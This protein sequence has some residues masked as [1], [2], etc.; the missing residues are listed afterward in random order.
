ME[1][2]LGLSKTKAPI[3]NLVI[4]K[5]NYDFIKK[6]VLNQAIHS[7]KHCD[8]PN[9]IKSIKSLMETFS[10]KEHSELLY[11][12]RPNVDPFNLKSSTLANYRI[13]MAYGYYAYLTHLLDQSRVDWLI[14]QDANAVF[15]GGKKT[16]AHFLSGTDQIY[17]YSLQL[18]TIAGI[19]IHLVLDNRPNQR[20]IETYRILNE[21][22]LDEHVAMQVHATI[23]NNIATPY[24]PLH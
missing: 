8:N 11:K 14:S 24:I 16:F 5:D 2:L 7:S 15:K 17:H 12:I 21:L 23:F 22:N 19:V 10:F 4:D 9:T 18:T 13:A 1:N 3:E 20:Y 6:E